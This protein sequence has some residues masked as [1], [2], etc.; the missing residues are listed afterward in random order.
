MTA[1]AC[2]VLLAG[3]IF[4]GWMMA[5]Y[6][7]YSKEKGKNVATKEDIAEITQKIE[8]VKSEFT[9]QT[10]RLKSQ[11]TLLTNVKSDI[12]S[13]ERKAIIDANEKLYL[14]MSH[15]LEMPALERQ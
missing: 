1:I 15:I 8:S 7:S 2:I 13:L 9:Q 11:L 6:N 4:I 12:Y 10:E 5:Y 3:E 14:L